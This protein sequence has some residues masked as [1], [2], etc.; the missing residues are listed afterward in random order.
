MTDNTTRK[1][2]W[3]AIIEIPQKVINFISGGVK[4]IFTPADDNYPEVGTQP[5]EGEPAEKK[6]Y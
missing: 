2:F 3:Q 4:R 5:F 6:N 1:A